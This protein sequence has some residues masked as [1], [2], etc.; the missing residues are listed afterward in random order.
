ML[1]YKLSNN[2]WIWIILIINFQI[3]FFQILSLPWAEPCKREFVFLA[4]P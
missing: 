3:V 1:E 2:N 4:K